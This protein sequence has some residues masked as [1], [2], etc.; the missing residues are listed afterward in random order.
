VV[1][2]GLESFPLLATL[3]W[4]SILCLALAWYLGT[5]GKVLIGLLTAVLTLS[6]AAQILIQ[7]TNF[8]VL[9]AKIEKHTGI[10][11]TIDF[12]AMK[13]TVLG[14]KYLALIALFVLAALGIALAVNARKFPRRYKGPEQSLKPKSD[15]PQ[16]LWDKQSE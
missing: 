4:L 11:Q 16:A 1:S 6:G 5:L 9:L 2:S 3:P 7:Q 12:I 8:E 10:A 14:A 15:D 13:T